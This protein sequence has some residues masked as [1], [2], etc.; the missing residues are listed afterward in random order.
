MRATE[1]QLQAENSTLKQVKVGKIEQ[2]RS[3]YENLIEHQRGPHSSLA[4]KS[5]QGQSPLTNGRQLTISD[6]LV[7]TRNLV[8]GD[9]GPGGARTNGR[10]GD[11]N[12]QD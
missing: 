2:V 3:F 5:T 12:L 6:G 10:G 1:G 11:K 9:F 4:A 8:G 7:P